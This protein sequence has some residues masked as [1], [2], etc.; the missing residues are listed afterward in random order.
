VAFSSLGVASEDKMLSLDRLSA[1]RDVVN[2]R[3]DRELEEMTRT[4]SVG[5]Y[6]TPNELFERWSKNLVPRMKGLAGV[7]LFSLP[8]VEGRDPEKRRW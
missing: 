2:T 8:I 3:W 6:H 4:Q 1:G 7:K 5:S